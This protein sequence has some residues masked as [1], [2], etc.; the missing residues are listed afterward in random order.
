M[1]GAVRVY[2]V[3]RHDVEWDGESQKPTYFNMYKDK[4][5]AQADVNARNEKESERRH[6][7]YMWKIDER[8]GIPFENDPHRIVV[9]NKMAP[10]GSYFEQSIDVAA[11]IPK[12]CARQNDVF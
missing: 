11:E 8:V 3:G 7:L 5:K 1:G 2:L 4:A 12:P 10:W 6:E 9:L